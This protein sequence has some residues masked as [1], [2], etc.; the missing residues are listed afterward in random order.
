MI[1][2]KWDRV[3]RPDMTPVISDAEIE[4]LVEELIGDYKPEMLEKPMPV[5][6]EHFAETYLELSIDYQRIA[7]PDDTVVGAILTPY[8][9]RRIFRSCIRDV[10][11]GYE[12]ARR[13]AG[14]HMGSLIWLQHCTSPQCPFQ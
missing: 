1:K 9:T 8:L 10:N 13:M 11:F 5:N 3:H 4:A 7:S 12:K 2:F 6:T 14:Y